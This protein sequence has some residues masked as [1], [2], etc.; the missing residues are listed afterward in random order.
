[1]MDVGSLNAGVA[2]SREEHGRIDA[3]I[4][5]AA[6][7]QIGAIECVPIEARRRRFDIDGSATDAFSRR[8]C[9]SCAHRAR[10][11]SSTSARRSR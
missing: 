6:M 1:V 5:N 3:L 7:L 11:T 10:A 8:C 2:R 9:R 4:D